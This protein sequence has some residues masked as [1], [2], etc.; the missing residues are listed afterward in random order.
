MFCMPPSSQRRVVS[1]HTLKQLRVLTECIQISKGISLGKQDA[2]LR[3][4]GIQI[5]ITRFGEVK[6]A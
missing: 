1:S 3:M 5:S 2:R 4:K 6:E